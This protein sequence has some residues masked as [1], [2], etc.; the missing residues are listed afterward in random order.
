MQ[1]AGEP[2]GDVGLH[3]LVHGV[4]DWRRHESV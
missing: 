2:D 3:L 4:P 1:E